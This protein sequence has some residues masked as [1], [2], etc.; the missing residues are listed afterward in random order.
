MKIYFF[1]KKKSNFSFNFAENG[2]I[3]DNIIF[4][5]DRIYLNGETAGNLRQ[6]CEQRTKYF[7]NEF[8]ENSDERIVKNLQQFL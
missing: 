5:E 3:E 4:I 6:K 2:R 8:T 7:W 1:I